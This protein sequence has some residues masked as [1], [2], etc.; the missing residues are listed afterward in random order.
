M[1]GPALYWTVWLTLTLSTSAGPVYIRDQKLLLDVSA[2]D[3][4]SNGARPSAARRLII[5]SHVILSFF[6]Y[7]V[8]RT[9]F[10]WSD[11]IIENG[12]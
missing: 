12:Q 4:A 8:Y 5:M 2:D 9:H 6:G 7:Q 1:G 10:R 3:L 11:D